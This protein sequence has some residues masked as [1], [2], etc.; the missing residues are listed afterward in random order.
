M[1]RGKTINQRKGGRVDPGGPSFSIT[2]PSRGF[3]LIEIM[4]VIV[5]LGILAGL[6]LPRFMGRTEEAKRTK[7]R[8]QIENL[9][10]ALKMYKLDSG[11]YPS[12][13]QG[14][15]ALVQKPSTGQIPR[16]WRDGGYLEK[17]QVPSDPWGR[18]YVY[19]S[20]GVKNKDFDLKSLGGDGEEGGE[21]EN[22]DVER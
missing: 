9:E 11:V 7:A 14:L 6:V 12:T 4:V 16:Q 22:Q 3:T 17:A 18:P 10:S 8:L 1:V 13:E 5:I 20:P 15:E 2:R 19:L 21:E